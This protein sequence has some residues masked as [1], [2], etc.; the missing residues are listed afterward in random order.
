MSPAWPL[1]PDE[2]AMRRRLC[3][4]SFRSHL[5]RVDEEVDALIRHARMFTTR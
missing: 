4:L 5:D 1:E 2:P 3:V